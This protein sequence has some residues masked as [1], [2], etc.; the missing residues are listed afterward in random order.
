MHGKAAR[1]SY[2]REAIKAEFLARAGQADARRV[3]LA[4]DASTRRY[5][6]VE[7][8][9]GPTLIFMDQPPSVETQPCPPGATPAERIAAGYNACARLSAGRI[10]AF[11]ACA[12]YL[13]G[14]GLSAPDILAHDEG[15]GLALLEDL[16]DDLYARL[17]EAGADETPLYQAAVDAL[18]TLH[19]EPPPER[20]AGYGLSWPLLVYDDLALKTG[21]DLF[22]E[23]WPKFA[24]LQ[25]FSGEAAA[26]W[27]ALWAPVRARAGAIAG[28]SGGVFAHRD[29]HAE[30]LVWLPHRAG[31]AR[32]GMLDFQDALRAHPAWDLLHLLQDARRDV[33]PELERAMLD[34]YLAAR[35]DLEREAFLRD[36]SALAALNAARILGPVFA[37][38]V[39]A[40]GRP[41]Y[42]AFMPRTWRYLERNLAPP[43]MESLRRWFDRHVPAEARA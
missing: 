31:I 30:N 29:Y 43:G 23:W 2:D 19:A 4:G 39:V 13:R 20:L 5:E 32:V 26:E 9:V 1:L 38:Q 25:P 37:R 17:I 18:I 27:E 40:F 41:K 36:Y 42:K 22:L 3:P 11:A 28:G 15:Q 16:G 8:R 14:C 21:S 6:R 35:P 24:G 34:R 33:S 10:E 12:G 7:P